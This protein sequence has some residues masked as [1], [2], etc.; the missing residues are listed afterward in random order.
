L[1]KIYESEVS[2]HP[3]RLSTDKGIMEL[4]KI[5]PELLE[6]PGVGV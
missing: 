5:L 3:N 4:K 2:T 1:Q 6:L